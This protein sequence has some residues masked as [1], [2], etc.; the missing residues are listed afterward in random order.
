MDLQAVVDFYILLP[1]L[2]GALFVG[3]AL[4]FFG[5]NDKLEKNNLTFASLGFF[6]LVFQNL[7]N[8]GYAMLVADG[9]LAPLSENVVYLINIAM[10]SLSALS[11]LAGSFEYAHAFSWMGKAITVPVF[12]LFWGGCIFFA[13]N[14]MGTLQD[15]FQAT[16]LAVGLFILGI[17]FC[18]TRFARTAYNLRFAGI[19][20]L[21]LSFYYFQD[22]FGLKFHSWMIECCLY[23]ALTWSI[24]HTTLHQLRKEIRDMVTELKSAKAKIPLFIQSSPFPVMI[25]ALKDDHLLVANEKACDLFNIDKNNVKQFRTEEYYVDANVHSELLQ[26]LSETPVVENFQALLR[27]ANSDETFW[28]EISARVIDYENEVALYS[29]FKDITEQKKRERDL[30]AKAVLDPLTGCYNRRQFQELA[31]REIRSSAR[32]NTSFCVIMM[33]IDHFK[34]VNDTYGHAFGDEVLKTLARVCKATIR[35]TDIF[36]RYGGEE[37]ICMLTQTDLTQG[38]L[39][40]ERIRSNIEKTTV[41][42]P[43]GEAFNF[44]VSIGITDSLSSTEL[45][46]LIK[47][48]DSALYEAKENGRNQVRVYGEP[49]EQQTKQEEKLPE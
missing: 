19:F 18:V 40:A 20:V 15:T 31:A 24:Y 11:M 14:G 17:S 43:S 44:S 30:F 26:R 3:S 46:G 10:I 34:N 38:K 42:Q 7:F 23:I 21:A 12:L 41:R 49:V 48:A 35:N 33:D 13:K 16:Y 37:F 47:C 2:F 36:A 39:V 29:A 4:Y 1:G 5:Q 25:S 32:Y 8:I 6:I 9:K 45:E 22:I 28:L 27:K